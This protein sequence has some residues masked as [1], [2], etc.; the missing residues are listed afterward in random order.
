MLVKLLKWTLFGLIALAVIV[1]AAGYYY[2]RSTTLPQT[3]GRLAMKGLSDTVEITRDARGIL[4]I[5]AQNLEDLFFGQGVAHAQDRLWQ[6]EFQRRLGAGTLAEVLG[7]AAVETDEFMRTLGV[8]R[9]AEAAY[10]ALSPQ[11]RRL[12]DAYVRGINAY[13]AT[14]PPLPLEFKLLG[15][16]PRPWR[17]ADVLVW[18]KLMSWDLSGNYEKELLRYK[19]LA[20]GLSKARINE[21]LPPY[22]DDAP[23]VLQSV[24]ARPSRNDGALAEALLQLDRKLSPG[25][26]ASNNWVV[27]GSR[28]A[29]GKPLL[30]NDPHL[31]LSTP[32][33]WILNELQA[34]GFYAV[35]ASFPGLPGV[36]I[37]HNDR[38]AWGVTNVGADVQ[39]LYVLEEKDGGY[40]YKGQ[41]RPYR[42][43]KETIRV[44]GQDP[45]TILV[46]ETVYGPVISDVVKAPGEK[47]LALRW[48]SLDPGDTTLE[49]FLRIDQARDWKSFNEA[50][51]YYVAPSQNF[52]YADVEGNIG[53]LAPGKI[54]IRKPGHSGA[55]PVVG[56][57][58]WDWQGFIPFDELPRTLNPPQGYVVTANNKVTPKAYPYTIT[59]DWAD[60]YRARRITELITAKPKL[61]VED[62]ARIQA[63][64]VSL[65]FRDFRP[66]I[67]LLQPK[68]E[69]GKKWKQRLLAWEGREDIRSEEATVFEAWYTELTRLPAKEVGQAH[70]DQP[71]YLLKAMREGD[72]A[73]GGSCLGFASQALDRVVE[74]LGEVK[75]WGQVH[76]AVF[77]H[78]VMSKDDRVRR[79]FERKIAHGGDRFTVNVGP[80]R[81]ADFRMAWG[82]SYREIVDLSALEKS[83]FIHPMGQSGNV[84]SPNYDDLLPLWAQNRYLPMRRGET[85]ARLVLEPAP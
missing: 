10:D 38:I 78:F 63:D 51:A 8:Y 76:Q 2:L 9:A 44:K 49:A 3:T 73:C 23:T 29:S 42:I 48:I 70:W 43:R 79:I 36:V 28:T 35:G 5:E 50:L 26:E 27:A 77:V 60:P 64:E 45:V 47:P 21:L 25:I 81:A 15:F 4:K 53:Y 66:V 62:M 84:M 33:I 12:L 31:R 85:K 80:Y 52:V 22:P 57:G 7:P 1:F 34:P 30:A 55:Y 83:R 67:A 65:L 74:R 71:R 13:L 17:A 39:D 59:V 69:A 82:P 16:K 58:E 75:P 54:P 6:M 32:S 18:A 20:R 61:D 68:S 11:T 19:L 37:G 24:A 14:N 40:L 56:T 41:V 72:L 46:R